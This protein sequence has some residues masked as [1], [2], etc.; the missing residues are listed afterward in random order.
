VLEAWCEL[1]KAW[2]ELREGLDSGDDDAVQR[3][4]ALVEERAS[5]E[6]GGPVAAALP[7][8]FYAPRDLLGLY[9]AMRIGNMAVLLGLLLR[10]E[11]ERTGTWPDEIDGIRPEVVVERPLGRRWI[12]RKD[13]KTGL[14]GIYIQGVSEPGVNIVGTSVH[15]DGA[16]FKFKRE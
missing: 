11:H 13:P 16:F 8:V 10:E 15:E 9:E 12:L 14:P 1:R 5:D 7:A 3:V 2:T 4:F 6:R